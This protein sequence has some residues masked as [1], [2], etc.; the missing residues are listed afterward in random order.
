[1][2]AE[3]LEERGQDT[4]VQVRQALRQLQNYFCSGYSI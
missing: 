4:V 1:M 2:Q 3:V